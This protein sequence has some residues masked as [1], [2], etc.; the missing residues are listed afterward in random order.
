VDRLFSSYG[1]LLD[2]YAELVSDL[3][4]GEQ[5]ALFYEN[6]DRIFKLA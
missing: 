2:A 3:S 1:D 5:R 6:A 4:E